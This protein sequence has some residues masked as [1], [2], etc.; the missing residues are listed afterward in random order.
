MKNIFK[1][2]SIIL[3]VTYIAVSCEKDD[4]SSRLNAVFSYYAD[5]FSVTF[6]NFS[7]NAKSYVWNFNDGSEESTLKNPVHVFKG[8]GNYVVE[9]TA[10]N[11]DQQDVFQDTVKIYGP[12]IKIDGNFTDW[13]YVDYV[14]ENWSD[15]VE[16][17][18][19]AKVFV[20]GNNINFYFEGTSEMAFTL[21]DMYI[22]SDNNAETGFWSWQW[23]AG[24]GAEYLIEGSPTG[25]WGSIYLNTDP[26]HGWSWEEVATFD[27]AC[28]FSDVKSVADGNAIEFSI[29]KTKIGSPA[30]TITF[31][32]SELDESWA[33]VG[34]IPLKELENSAFLSVRL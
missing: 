25:G 27:N 33:A 3:S 22:N 14:F 18:L 12:S 31:A 5:G 4:E 19:A 15:T 7:T 32:I 26:N 17:L 29:D 13:E 11:G 9:L 8:K 23:P 21:F 30:G 16:T 28:K 34:S 2:I 20:Y 24:S 1:I 6:T 10:V